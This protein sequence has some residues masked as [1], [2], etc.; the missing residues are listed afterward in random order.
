MCVVHAGCASS[1]SQPK[2]I[3]FPRETFG[4]PQ[5]NMNIIDIFICFIN[6]KKS[7]KMYL[8][9]S[10]CFIKFM[11]CFREEETRG[12]ELC[13]NIVLCI[14]LLYCIMLEYYWKVV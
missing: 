4:H 14:L 8:K 1:G 2:T 6:N 10:I 9:L 7:K 11:N 13:W 12:T 3:V 5:L